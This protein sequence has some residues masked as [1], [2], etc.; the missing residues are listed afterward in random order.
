MTKPDPSAALTMLEAIRRE[1]HPDIAAELLAEIYQC[2]HDE[3]FE[4]ERGVI[5]AQLRD[6]IGAHVSTGSP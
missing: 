4:E 2:E 5:Q 3:Q 1:K 6:L